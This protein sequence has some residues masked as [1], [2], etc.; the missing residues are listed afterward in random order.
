MVRT[1]FQLKALGF[2]ALLLGLMAFATSA[3]AEP[4]AKWAILKANNELVTIANPALDPKG[5]GDTLLPEIQVKEIEELKDEKDPG[6]HLVLHTKVA[7]VSVLILC[8]KMELENADGTGLPKLLLEGKVLGRIKFTECLIKLNGV[9][10]A[11]CKP[12]SPGAASGTILTLLIE[13]LIKLHELA[14]KTKDDIVLF[15][16]ENKEGKLEEHFVTL[17]L[18]EECAIGETLPV[19]GW[20]S[21]KDCQ[22][23]FLSHQV[24][25]LVEEFAPL[26]LLYVL[27]HTEE[28]KAQILGSVVLALAGEHK[29][30]K[31]SGLPG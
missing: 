29:G 16:G 18:G 23:L 9:T 2:C 30:L 1:R 7:G 17:E 8:A 6:K 21:I 19:K 13:G 12:H 14:D 11:A 4:T 5:I 20:F 24:D 27:S 31:W 3:Q 28:H 22:N 25:H 15:I 10:T 26:T